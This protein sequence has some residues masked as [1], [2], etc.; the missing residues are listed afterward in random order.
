MS[1]IRCQIVAGKAFF[2]FQLA[3]PFLS[4]N[5]LATVSH[6]FTRFWLDRYNSSFLRL[7]MKELLLLETG[8]VVIASPVWTQNISPRCIPPFPF[9]HI[10]Q[11]SLLS[12][13]SF[14]FQRK[15]LHTNKLWQ[16]QR[17]HGLATHPL[18]GG[19][20]VSASFYPTVNLI[21]EVGKLLHIC[22]GKKHPPYWLLAER[23]QVCTSAHPH[24][25]LST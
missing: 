14:T 7:S 25:K 5:D 11:F 4:D 8:W 20:C 2:I 17:G 23:M 9:S 16:D 24:G 15:W 1:T 13:T 18:L 3:T 21:W 6:A 22:T 19:T 10:P 12:F